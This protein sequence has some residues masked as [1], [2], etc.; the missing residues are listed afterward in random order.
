ML[1]PVRYPVYVSTSLASWYPVPMLASCLSLYSWIS[2]AAGLP[3][4]SAGD[5]KPYLLT[6]LVLVPSAPS[7]CIFGLTLLPLPA[8]VPCCGLGAAAVPGPL[9]I[10][11]LPLLSLIALVYWV[12]EGFPSPTLPCS[13]ST[14]NPSPSGVNP[15]VLSPRG[16][17][18]TPGCQFPL[19]TR[20]PL[21]LPG[22]PSWGFLPL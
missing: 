2:A 15:E 18:S 19:A 14:G 22:D 16:N 21:P 7:G 8:T 13:S 4:G 6:R 5:S 17:S 11:S 10:Y 1:C 3:A 9:V 20:I 12:V